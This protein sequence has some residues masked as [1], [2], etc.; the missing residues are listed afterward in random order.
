MDLQATVQKLR[1]FDP[2]VRKEAIVALANSRDKRVLKPLK[3]VYEN[4]DDPELRNLALRAAKFIRKKTDDDDTTTSTQND[5]Y[6]AR[7]ASDRDVDDDSAPSWIVD[8]APRTTDDSPRYRFSDDF[9]GD[10]PA[11]A[12]TSAGSSAPRVSEADRKFARGNIERAM[13]L[14]IRG[15]YLKAQTLVTQAFERD[16]NLQHDSMAVG[17]AADLF[18]MREAEVIRMLT[19]SAQRNRVKQ[20]AMAQ[21]RKAQAQTTTDEFYNALFWL[22]IYFILTFLPVVAGWALLDTAF[23]EAANDPT[24]TADQAEL[25]DTLQQVATVTII[26]LAV[27]L[28]MFQ[29][30]YQMVYVYSV[31]LVAKF[32]FLGRGTYLGMLTKLTQISIVTLLVSYGSFASSA[33]DP[34]LS[35]VV[36]CGAFLYILGVL[37]WI[38]QTISKHYD[39]GALSGCMTVIISTILLA[40]GQFMFFFAFIALLEAV[41]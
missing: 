27:A 2:A 33:I 10:Q 29:T 36:S 28:A 24:L 32:F 11:G 16:P 40:V 20:N 5:P 9:Y 23:E 8:D 39:V 1:D 38:V 3:W 13:E 34:V 4:D 35:T 14:K 7:Y 6:G 19:D 41:A 26:L 31:H 12:G 22:I 18:E 25:F 21:Q 17:L 30:F 37:F 15:N